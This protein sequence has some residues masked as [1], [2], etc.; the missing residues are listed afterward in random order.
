M[1]GGGHERGGVARSRGEGS[2]ETRGWPQR[3]S[4]GLGKGSGTFRATRRTRPWAKNWH[5]G[6]KERRPQWEKSRGSVTN[7]GVQLCGLWGDTW[8]NKGMGRVLNSSANSGTLGE[9]QECDGA[10]GRRRRGSGCARNAPVSAD[11]AN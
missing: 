5:G 8:R 10:S 4:R 1:A 11:Q 2:P 7:S 3:G 6:A 9:R